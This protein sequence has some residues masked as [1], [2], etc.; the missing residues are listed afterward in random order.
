LYWSLAATAVAF[1]AGLWFFLPG[2]SAK[3]ITDPFTGGRSTQPTDRAVAPRPTLIMLRKMLPELVK[4]A[5]PDDRAA[6]T[7]FYGEQRGPLIWVTETGLSEK[8]RAVISEVRKA[9]DWGLHSSD[10]SVPQLPAGNLSPEI[11]AE[12][13]I[14]LT[15]TVLKYARYARGGR[16]SDPSRISE[17]LDYTPPVRPPKLVL[18]DIAVADAPDAYL[19]SLHPKHEQFEKLHQRLLKLRRS[20]G[21]KEEVK[22]PTDNKDK[23]TVYVENLQEAGPQDLN[24][25]S[26]PESASGEIE[27]IL[28]NMERWRWLP[29]D[30]GKLYVWDNVPEA[31]ARVVK[32][33]KTIHSDRIIV[34]QP[35]WPTPSFSADMKLVVF[36]PTWGVPDGIKVKELSPILRKS[37]GGLFG[38][39]GGGYS[40][41][42]VLEAYQLRAYVNGHPVDANSIDWNSID[43][44][45]VTFQQPPGPKNPLGDVKFMFP[46]K[47]D[48]Y[49]HDTP[50]RDLFARSF[51]ALSHGCMRVEHPRRLATVLL[52]EDKGWSEAK[53]GSLFNGDS[54]EV[55]LSTHIPVHVTYFT[56]MVD[57]EGK[58]RTFGDLY[59]LDDRVGAALFG[60]KVRFETPRYDDEPVASRQQDMR[61]QGRQQQSSGPSTLAEA[62]SDIF[63]P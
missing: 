4:R 43:I 58:L 8:G 27:R 35:T 61:G 63:S 3:H 46:N 52:A 38:L 5:H 41:E 53:V 51:R 9:D 25:Q 42:S 49:M 36:H 14:K 48:V 37:S 47:H 39:F 33:G 12:T 19:R 45:A 7:T 40:A 16:I 56:A 26:K 1:V 31:L 62:I 13:E 28:I 60:R 32:D 11:A 24:G 44:R 21:S 2:T 30:L 20:D 15:L 17:L 55:Q 10:F 57:Y 18:T 6:V 59:G 50:D 22:L 29:E 34:G 54:Q 23:W